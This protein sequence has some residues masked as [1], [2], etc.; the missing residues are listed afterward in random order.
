MEHR[1]YRI[2][3]GIIGIILGVI[4][5]L[6]LIITLRAFLVLVLVAGV[7]AAAM[8][9]PTNWFRRVFRFKRRG[10]AVALLFLAGLIVLGGLGYLVYRPV[11]DQSQSLRR[12]LPNRVERVKDLP[13]IGPRLKNVDLR[14]STERFFQELPKRLEGN[15][16]LILGVA[17]TALTVLVLT[18]T[19]LVITVF[20]LLNGP[21]M[22]EGV[23]QLIIDPGRAARAQ[24]L[25]RG[26][27]DSVAGYVLGNLLI[28]VCASTVTA[29]TLGVCRAP[30]VMVLSAVMFILD[31]IPL[32][33]ATL[34]G[35]IVTAATFILDPQPWKALVFAIVFIVYQQIEN[36]TL[37]PV[38]MGRTVKLG[39]FPV[40]LITLAGS[41]LAGILGALLAIPIGAALNVVVQDIL[42]ERKRRATGGP[43]DL[44]RSVA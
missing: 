9:R 30:F 17:Q 43:A 35:V 32:V 44:S 20:L 24:R 22:A 38:I 21:R 8:D 16:E 6:W 19:C 39:A 29:I 37:Y 34:G 11:A 1:I 3:L 40:F 7:L 31:L 27:L 5:G 2:T 41:E 12:D 15:R 14:G 25:G 18:T 23:R 4:V 10:P 28:S 33:G 13:I 26:M 36:H 42:T